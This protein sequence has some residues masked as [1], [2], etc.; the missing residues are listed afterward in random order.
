MP[1]SQVQK[2]RPR[3]AK[4]FTQSLMGAEPDLD[5]ISSDLHFWGFPFP[6]G[7]SEQDLE[8]TG[9]VHVRISG[10]GDSGGSVDPLL[11][12]QP[13]EKSHP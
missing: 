6:C 8:E 3:E 12:L 13:M 5:P 4:S 10:S 9:G 11:P 7:L 1:I 2:Q